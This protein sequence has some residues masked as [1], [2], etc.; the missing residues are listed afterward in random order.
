VTAKPLMRAI[1]SLRLGSPR[2][3]LMPSPLAFASR[4][5]EN[6]F[7]DHCPHGS[8]DQQRRPFIPRHIERSAHCALDRSNREHSAEEGRDREYNEKARSLVQPFLSWGLMPSF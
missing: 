5:G 2:S 1:S 4:H 8:C 6:E 7:A 3:S